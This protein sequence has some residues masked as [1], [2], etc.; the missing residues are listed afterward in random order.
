MSSLSQQKHK[1]NETKVQI[2]LT[3]LITFCAAVPLT[4]DLS[5]VLYSSGN[6]ENEGIGNAVCR[7]QVGCAVA[8]PVLLLKCF[9]TGVRRDSKT[10]HK[11]QTPNQM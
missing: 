3:F 8:I 6:D 10:Q 2:T 4:Y 11:K 9:I 1:G 7:A 5:F